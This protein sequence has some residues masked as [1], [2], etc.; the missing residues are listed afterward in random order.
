MVFRTFKVRALTESGRI[1]L[2]KN[3][4]D[5][6]NMGRLDKLI[7]KKLFDVVVSENFDL[8][9]FRGKTQVSLFVDPGVM[10]SKIEESMINEGC[11]LDDF[12][13]LIE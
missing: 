9:E 2:E 12:E 10:R 1:A 13:I 7:M 6:E 4:A 3:V 11:G 8:L 5:R